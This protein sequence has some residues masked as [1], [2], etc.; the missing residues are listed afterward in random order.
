[1]E[2]APASTVNRAYR[3]HID[4]GSIVLPGLFSHIGAKR[5]VYNTLLAEIMANYAECAARKAA[6]EELTKDDYLGTSH[7]DL[8]RLMVRKARRAGSLVLI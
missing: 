5:F 4:P 7:I 6:G 2:E 3:Y 8:Q 1:M